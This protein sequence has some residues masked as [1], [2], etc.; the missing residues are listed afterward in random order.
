[1]SEYNILPENMY[2]MDESRFKLAKLKLQSVLLTV[3][4]R[5]N[6]E[7]RNQ[8]ESWRKFKLEYCKS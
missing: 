6:F 8:D 7:R 5:K 1:M 3:E 4:F 2:N